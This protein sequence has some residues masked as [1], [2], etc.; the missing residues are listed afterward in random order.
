MK[1]K[2]LLPRII[3]I[4]TLIFI[5]L[6]LLVLLVNSFN[7]SRVSSVWGGFSFKWYTKLFNDK[8]LLRSIKNTVIVTASSVFISTIMGTLAGVTLGRYKSRLQKAH[9][10]IVSLPLI[11]PDILIGIS[12]LLFFLSLKIRLSLFTIILGHIT[13]SIS[14]VTSTV[15]AR[16]EDFDFSVIEAAQDLG[17]GTMQILWSIYL[18]LLAPGILSGAML[19]MTLSL[20]DFIITFF[21]AGPGAS[22]LPIQ[23]YSMIRHGSPP[24]INALSTLFLVFTF[25]IVLIYQRVTRRLN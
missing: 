5:Y 18:P 10:T 8:N 20:D 4:L 2:S 11:M 12:L 7:A 25:L 3:L 19:A 6:P 21:T 15:Q 16:F 17:A 22:T 23:I 9:M 13:F 14:Y 24:V 1:K